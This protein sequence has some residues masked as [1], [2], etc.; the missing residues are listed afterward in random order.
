[1][2]E[3]RMNLVREHLKAFSVKDW[4]LYKKTLVPKVVYEE[5]ATSRHAEGVDDVLKILKTWTVAFPDLKAT[6]KNLLVQE[7]MVMAEILWEGTHNGTLKGPFGEIPPTGKKGKL[8]SVEL[9][10]FEGDKIR[11]LRHYFDLMTVLNQIGVT[12]PTPPIPVHI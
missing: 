4:E 12:A 7:D 3:K 9:F 2:S 5:R 1:M 10:H 8:N 6:V 11:E